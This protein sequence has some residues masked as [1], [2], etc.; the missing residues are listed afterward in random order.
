MQWSIQTKIIAVFSAVVVII[1]LVSLTT[2]RNAY[3][4][5]DAN[6]R[7]I[8]SHEVEDELKAILSLFKDAETG[9]RGFLLTGD[10]Q[11][12]KPYLS[13][14]ASLDKMLLSVERLVAD[15]P[16]QTEKIRQLK[17]LVAEKFQELDQT[18]RL[19]RI[20]GLPAAQEVVRLGSGK[21][22]M[23]QIRRL[24]GEMLNIE[25]GLLNKRIIKVHRENN[26]T[27]FAI[28]A[29]TLLNLLLLALG[30]YAITKHLRERR[31]YE[32]KIR[33]LNQR[34]QQRAEKLACD[35]GESGRSDS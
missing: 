33:Q 34:L 4:L 2:Y 19:R 29:S 14:T 15:N 35:S 13:A 25:E 28:I 22:R 20:E 7:V 16:A 17:P 5:I 31:E 23:D 9:Q 8:H 3:H 21:D 1:I 30:Y 18:I 11:Y 10:E 24:I 6:Q 12:L 26:S 32:A 27:T